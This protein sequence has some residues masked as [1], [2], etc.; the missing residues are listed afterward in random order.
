MAQGTTKGVPIDIDPS[1]VNNSDVLVPSQK[2][3]KTYV[4]SLINGIDWKAA[5]YVVTTVALPAC[6]VSGPYQVLTATGTG[7]IPS[8]TLDNVGSVSVGQ[9]ILVK[10]QGSSQ[11]NGIYVVTQVGEVSATPWILTRASDANTAV[12]LQEATVGVISGST[13]KNS[14]FHC[15]PVTIPFTL[16]VTGLTFVTIGTGVNY[17]FDEPLVATGSTISLPAANT[18]VNGHLTSTDWTR[19]DTAYTDRNKWDGGATGL[20]AATGRTSLGATTLGSNLFASSNGQGANGFLIIASDD[21]VNIQNS[22][23]YK[24]ALGATTLGNNLF[25]ATDST[26]IRFLQVNANNSVSW[27]DAA[28]F[29]TAIGAMPGGSSDIQVTIGAG[30]LTNSF[31]SKPSLS[32]GFVTG[33]TTNSGGIIDIVNSATAGLQLGSLQFG[34]I[35]GSTALTAAAIKA[36]AI[37]GSSGGDSGGAYLSFQTAL[38]GTG[39]SPVERMRINNTGNILM[40]STD[41]TVSKLQVTGITKFTGTSA[42]DT[43]PLGSELAAVTASGTGWTLAGTN[44]NV[45][46]Y[47]H[48]AGPVAS[49]SATTTISAV[50]TYYQITYTITGRTAG[51]VTITYG[52]TST[53]NITASGNTGPIATAASTTIQVTPDTAFNGTV[54]L[55]IKSIGTSSASSI[56][57]NSSGTSNIEIRAT[58]NSNTF[59]GLNAGNRNT[60]GISNTILGSGAGFNNTSSSLNTFIGQVAGANNSIGGSNTFLGSSSGNSNNIGANNVFV[61]ANAASN[62]TSGSGTVAIGAGAGRYISGGSTVM[63]YG[64]NSV[65]IGQAAYPR[66]DGQTGQIAIGNAAVG[67]GSNTTV[68]GTSAITAN[69]VYGKQYFSQPTPTALTAT[70]TLTIANLLTSIITVTSAVSVTLTLPT[71]TLTDAGAVSGG[72]PANGAFDWCVINLGSSVGAILMAGDTGH[73]FVGNTVVAIS[74]S[75]TFRTV[76]TTTNTYITYRIT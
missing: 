35:F 60:T 15:Q 76:K 25:T 57:T 38:G 21:V 36:I 65:F 53:S 56:F 12:L 9:R 40:G 11:N 51:S 34:N 10:D 69:F 27:L 7:P 48:T 16:G 1:L 55:S 61:G 41:D 52:G 63:A 58:S 4:D 17:T 49:L 70:A 6:T 62:N 5:V 31:G 28:G 3:I 73:T 30:V 54:V 42:T 50:S 26:T 32:A 43:A 14:Q 29:R 64:N 46:G 22:Y 44:L 13:F 19:F 37:N 47:T 33:G 18:S 68:V 20:D 72:L 67:L 71:G 45:G 59:I 24:Q 23:S 74:T 8:A 66:A 2:A 75:A 39:S